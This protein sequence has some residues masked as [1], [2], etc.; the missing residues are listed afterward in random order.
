M[1]LAKTVNNYNEI[2]RPI[3][4]VIIKKNY[5]TNVTEKKKNNVFRLGVVCDSLQ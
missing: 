3:T 2:S 4:Q 1:L 5:L